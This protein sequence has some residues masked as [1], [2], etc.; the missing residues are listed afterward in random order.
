MAKL[1][2]RGLTGEHLG[3]RLRVQLATGEVEEVVALELTVCDPPEP[4]CGLTYR[5]VHASKTS[6]AK[7]EGSVHWVA[8]DQIENFQ[9]LGDSV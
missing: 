4:C 2:A 1:E 5:L 8:F 6:K 9:K 3:K 7:A